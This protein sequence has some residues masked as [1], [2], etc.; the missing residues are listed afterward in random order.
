[1]ARKK[2]FDFFEAMYQLSIKAKEASKVLDDIVVNY[3]RDYLKEQAIKIHELEREGDIILAEVM[4]ELNH[5]FI[6]PIDREDIV[7]IINSID[8]VLDSINALSFLFDDL[9]IQSIRE[10]TTDMTG[11]IVEAV[12]G[13]TIVTKEFSKFKS[14][15]KI[16]EMIKKVVELEGKADIIHSTQIKELFTQEE[17]LLEVIRWKD[18]FNALEATINNTEKAVLIME[19]MVIKNS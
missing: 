10:K 7:V 3:S 5:S 14:T 8:D 18:I 6:T 4:Y 17:N 12:E 11:F 2:G 1:M 15:K 9:A 13:L 16:G 19:T